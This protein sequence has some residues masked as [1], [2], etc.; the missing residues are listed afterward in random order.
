MFP[1][2]E[3]PSPSCTLYLSARS[4]I[5]IRLYLRLESVPLHFLSRS[6]SSSSFSLP[7]PLR[8]PASLRACV[9]TAFR[10]CT[11]PRGGDAAAAT[12]CKHSPLLFAIRM[13]PKPAPVREEPAPSLSIV[14]IYI[15]MCICVCMYVCIYT[16]RYSISRWKDKFQF[17]PVRR[18]ICAVERIVFHPV[19]AGIFHGMLL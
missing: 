11:S 12:T 15:C 19:F 13:P 10:L 2:Q 14:C 18:E 7:F 1:G 8:T 3:T 6:S 4:P 5:F 16:S 9:Y 17:A